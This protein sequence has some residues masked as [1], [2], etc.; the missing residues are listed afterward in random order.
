MIMR[1]LKLV[2][3]S[4]QDCSNC[5]DRRALVERFRRDL[6]AYVDATVRLATL[7]EGPEFNRAHRESEQARYTFTISRREL[8]HHVA[9]H[10]CG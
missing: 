4:L 2:E 6:L 3:H 5:Q 1:N 8:R 7:S 9:M 10:G